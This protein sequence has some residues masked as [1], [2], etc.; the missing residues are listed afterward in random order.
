ME[1]SV[2]LQEPF[3]YSIIPMI[4]I[5]ILTFVIAIYIIVKACNKVRKE[6]TNITKIKYENVNNII[7]IKQKYIK[8]LIDLEKKL[9][10]NNISIREAYQKLS[11]T[12]RYFVYEVTNIKVQNYTLQ[13]IKKLDMPILYEWVE[14]YYVPEFS[15]KSIG[16]IK[17]SIEKTRK[18]IEKWS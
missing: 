17:L 5:I 2:N 16:N 14:E 18:V 10:N 6:K 9:D 11:S 3:S 7:E 1:V 13:D 15:E 12:I 4:V 8:I